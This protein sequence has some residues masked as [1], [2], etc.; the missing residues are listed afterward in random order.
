MEEIH[1]KECKNENFS[2]VQ[3]KSFRFDSKS[4]SVHEIPNVNNYYH[5]ES[6]CQLNFTVTILFS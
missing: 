3:F 2:G 1:S 4:I 6:F 5:N